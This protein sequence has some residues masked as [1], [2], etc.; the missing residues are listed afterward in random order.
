LRQIKINFSNI[1][2]FS[3]NYAQIYIFLD[4]LENSIHDSPR[5]KQTSPISMK[6]G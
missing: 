4:Y 1:K 6:A 5:A 3:I 2:S